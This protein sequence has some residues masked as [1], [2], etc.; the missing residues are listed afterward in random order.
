MKT[1]DATAE[2]FY[3]AFNALKSSDREAFIE[4]VVSDPRLR[5]DL[6]DV[7]L[8]EEAKKIKGR[9]VSARDYFARRR[10]DSLV[11]NGPV[12]NLLVKTDEHN[13]RY[14]AL[15]GFEDHTAVGVGDETETAI[16]E[17]RAKGGVILG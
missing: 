8:I 14:V 13:G 16:A 3:T 7:L 12:E 9:S 10:K 1:A 5:Q 11:G 6:V 4:K 2:V 17:A 15:K